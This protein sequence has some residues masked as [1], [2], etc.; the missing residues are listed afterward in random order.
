MNEYRVMKFD[1]SIFLTGFMASGKSSVGKLLAKKLDRPFTDLD[2]LIEKAE[3]QSIREIFDKYGESYFRQKEWDQ[4]LE[5]TKSFK[6]VVALGGGALHN[7]NVVDHLKLH[8]LMIFIKTPI[9]V[10]TNRVLRNTR[11]P[12]AIAKNGKLKSRQAL[13]DELNILYLAR[14]GY[15]QQAQIILESTDEE[16]KEEQ[17]IKI[18]EKLQR[19]V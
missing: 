17:V 1:E 12:M 19:Y 2:S 7:Q 4:L 18:F 9:E 11:R 6:G 5:V 15:Y 8:G 16:T 3:K 13:F 14:I 10:I